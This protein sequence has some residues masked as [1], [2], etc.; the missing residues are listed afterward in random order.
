[1]SIF[2]KSETDR[3]ELQVDGQD[4]WI[5]VRR[6]LTAGARKKMEGSAFTHV[7][8]SSSHAGEVALSFDPARMSVAK[9]VAYLVDWSF[10]DEGTKVPVSKAMVEMLTEEAYAVIEKAIDAHEARVKGK[11]SEGPATSTLAMSAPVSHSAE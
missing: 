5:E 1:M 9:I 6:R 2:V 4:H 7:E 10:T 11:K 3:I 8:E